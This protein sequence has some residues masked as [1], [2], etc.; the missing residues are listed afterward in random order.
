[1][2]NRGAKH[3][4]PPGNFERFEYLARRLFAVEKREIEEQQVLESDAKARKA[5]SAH[6]FIQTLRRFA[7]QHGEKKTLGCSFCGKREQEVTYLVAGGASS[8]YICGAC[9]EK[10]VEIVNQAKA[11]GP[12]PNPA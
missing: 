8:V 11:S 9:I 5:P 6:G 7:M 12:A 2:N 10:C 3:G 4:A 1:M